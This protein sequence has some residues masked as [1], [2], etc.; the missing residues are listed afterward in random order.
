MKQ[1]LVIGI[2]QGDSNGIGYEVIIK[3]LSNAAVLDMFTP[4]VY[5]SSKAFGVY[6][7]QIPETENINTN[8]IVSA[9]D[10]HPKRVNIVNCTEEDLPI[11]PGV[12]THNSAKAAIA[13]L[14]MAVA[15]AKAGYLDVIVTAPFSKKG[16]TL[17]HF[18][19]AGHTGYLI[20][21]FGAQDGLMFMCSESLRVGVVTMHIPLREVSDAITTELILSKL[22]LMNH[23]LKRDFCIEHPKI[24][25][26]G[27]N[28]HAGD[29]GLLGNEEIN[30]IIPAIKAAKEEGIEAFGPFPP[31]GFFAA[32]MQH[33]YDAVLTMYHDQG[34]IPFK[35]LSFDTGV[36]FTA[37]LP[38]VRT[39]PDHG[40]AFDIAGQNRANP[41]SMLS[42]IYLAIDV[43]RNRER[44]DEIHAN[45]L[46][47]YNFGHD[48]PR[49]PK[50]YEMEQ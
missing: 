32:T 42:A 18:K 25:L 6:R 2:T 45:P 21:T 48:E 44:Y 26:L 34:L 50:P 31:D 24:A 23:S 10:A 38:I 40:T 41:R 9:K 47:P 19:Y 12:L 5:G 43:Y 16:V 22:R 13:S 15:E 29:R 14:E 1:K 33:Q 35:T 39:S 11:E 28:P 30:I 3:A 37:G 8:I 27:L 36:N 46:K 17:E 7:K 49:L 20:E 4:V